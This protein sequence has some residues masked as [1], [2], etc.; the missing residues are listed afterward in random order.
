MFFIM[1][2]VRKETRLSEEEFAPVLEGHKA[3]IAN[4]I[5]A[6]AILLAGPRTD[7]PGGFVV[8][9]AESLAAAEAFFLNDPFKIYDIQEYHFKSFEIHEHDACIDAWLAR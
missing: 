5:K 1:E 7:I 4:G 2:A 9:R 6:G 3:H 8:M